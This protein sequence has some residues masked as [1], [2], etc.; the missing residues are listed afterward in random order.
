M[1]FVLIVVVRFLLLVVVCWFLVVVRG[2][3]LVVC[4][5]SIFRCCLMLDV[6]C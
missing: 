3:L 6:V 2:W 5:L 1:C 4:V